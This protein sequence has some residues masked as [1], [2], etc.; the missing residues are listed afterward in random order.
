[1]MSHDE[2]IMLRSRLYDYRGSFILVRVTK[3]VENKAANGQ[4]VNN[5]NKKVIFNIVRCLLTA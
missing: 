1:M 5:D 3:T 2:R 4:L